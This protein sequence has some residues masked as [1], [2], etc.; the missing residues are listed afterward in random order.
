V[1]TTAPRL[2][3]DTGGGVEV[4]VEVVAEVH[5]QRGW[6]EGAEGWCWMGGVVAVVVTVLAAPMAVTMAVVG[7]GVCING[8]LR[9]H[10]DAGQC[11]SATGG[12]LR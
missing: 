6:E 1:L 10:V 3:S 7:P 2:A 12:R 8:V 11:T 9:G 5:E 4:E